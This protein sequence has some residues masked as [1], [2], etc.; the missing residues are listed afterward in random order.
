V[1]ATNAPLKVDGLWSLVFSAAS[2][3]DG[4]ATGAGSDAGISTRLFFTAGPNK[5]E[6]GVFG[7]LDQM[8]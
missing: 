4:G 3:A 5:E 2:V 6:N 8:P 1:D 7:H